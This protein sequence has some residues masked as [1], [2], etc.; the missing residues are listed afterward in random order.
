MSFTPLAD[1]PRP[2]AYTLEMKVAN[3]TFML[4]RL[5]QDCAPLQ[6]I[7]ELTE[8]AIDSI[9]ALGGHAG[10]IRWDVDWTRY[11]LE[12]KEGYKVAVIDTG[13]G[14]TGPE[15]VSFINQLSSSM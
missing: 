1:S 12:P 14:M 15:M 4:E 6:F 3:M 7:R 10:E 13:I 9:A 8:N 11:D 2:S 5:S